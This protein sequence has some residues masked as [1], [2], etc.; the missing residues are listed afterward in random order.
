LIQTVSNER[1]EMRKK[2]WYRSSEGTK[3]EDRGTLTVGDGAIDF[4]GKKGTASGPVRS[5]RIRPTGFTNWVHTQYEADGELRDAYFVSSALLGWS[6]ILGANKRLA[7]AI[8]AEIPA[9]S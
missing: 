7:E 6:G 1:E 8:E 2:V 3:I 4:A 5:V 9:R